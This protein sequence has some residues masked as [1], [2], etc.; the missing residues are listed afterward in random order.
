[1]KILLIHNRFRWL[2]PVSYLSLFI[3]IF[4]CSKWNHIAIEREEGVVESI[5]KGVTPKL[6]EDW[7]VI[8]DRIVQELLYDGPIALDIA[9]LYGKPYGLFDLLRV[10]WYIILTKWFGMD[11]EKVP[12]NSRGY[13]CS[14]LAAVVLGL[15]NPHLI[16][17]ADFEHM[18]HLTKGTTYHTVRK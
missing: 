12:H 1:M 4:T 6:K 5:G 10:G 16:T 18:P 9:L 17:P 2:S 7:A 8:S 13:I 11:V 15:K 3:R 14:E